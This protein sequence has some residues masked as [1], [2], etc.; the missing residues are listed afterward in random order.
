MTWKNNR[1]PVFLTVFPY[2]G[3]YIMNDVILLREK[4][5]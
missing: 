4:E 1:L 3:V 5:I 2:R